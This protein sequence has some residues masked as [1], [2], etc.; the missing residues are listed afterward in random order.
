[1]TTMDYL[2]PKEL[3]E[4]LLSFKTSIRASLE[5]DSFLLPLYNYEKV[6]DFG[7]LAYI[8]R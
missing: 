6:F 3:M 7:K 8:D 1:M 5:S 4:K 2:P